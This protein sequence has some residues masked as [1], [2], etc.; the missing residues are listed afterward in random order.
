MKKLTGSDRVASLASKLGEFLDR[1]EQSGSHH[2]GDCEGVL[3]ELKVVPSPIFDDFLE[4][5]RYVFVLTTNDFRILKDEF[6][7]VVKKRLKKFCVSIPKMRPAH[8]FCQDVVIHAPIA[9]LATLFAM[10]I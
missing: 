6:S 5:A 10:L 3:K 4:H 8:T 1:Y 2:H 7:I 9:Q